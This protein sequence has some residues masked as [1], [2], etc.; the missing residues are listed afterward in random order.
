LQLTHEAEKSPSTRQF[1]RKTFPRT[2]ADTP[3]EV[4]F[5]IFPTPLRA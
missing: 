4:A 2:S 1:G 3:I 5:V